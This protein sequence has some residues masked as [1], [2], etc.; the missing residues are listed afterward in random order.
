MWLS[1]LYLHYKVEVITQM[2][3]VDLTLTVAVK[4]NQGPL[5]A[6]PN[7]IAPKT[8]FLKCYGLRCNFDSLP[9]I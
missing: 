2:Q 8:K 7:K 9:L 6:F 1:H 3:N 4:G 5:P